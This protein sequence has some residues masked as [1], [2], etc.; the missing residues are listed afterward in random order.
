MAS[1]IE[2][3]GADQSGPSV[4]KEFSNCRASKGRSNVERWFVEIFV[5]RINHYLVVTCEQ[6][7]NLRYW[8]NHSRV[9]VS[10]A[11]TVT[12]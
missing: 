10:H 4:S 11:R 1:P 6:R 5:D 12:T 9:K 3:C 2:P 7:D 8:M